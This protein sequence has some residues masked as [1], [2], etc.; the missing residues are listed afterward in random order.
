MST[1][2][3]TTTER[4]VMEY[5]N[6]IRDSGV[7]NMF[8]ATPYIMDEFEHLSRTEATRILKLWMGNFNEAGNYETVKAD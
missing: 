6:V 8:G 5:L 1:R 3:T 2:A 4:E 7:T